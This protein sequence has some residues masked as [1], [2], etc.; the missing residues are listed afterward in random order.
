MSWLKG[1]PLI[2][3]PMAAAFG[4]V[5]PLALGIVGLEPTIMAGKLVSRYA[6]GLSAPL[7]TAVSGL[8]LAGLVASTKFLG[9]SFHKKAALAIA[10]AAGGVAYYQVRT[11][12]SVNT[13]VADELGS[14]P[15]YGQG[16]LAKQ[17]GFSGFPTRVVH[18]RY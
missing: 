12:G 13:P 16:P 14:I 5:G 4:M 17:L 18:A 9:A 8:I 11:S 15:A 6:P 3:K 1:I 2:G 7:V 10:S